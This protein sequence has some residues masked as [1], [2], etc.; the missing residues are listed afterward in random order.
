MQDHC[1]FKA[2]HIAM[3]TNDGL[4]ITSSIYTQNNAMSV[5][6]YKCDMVTEDIRPQNI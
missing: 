4:G 1:T 5:I 2:T 6:P 3:H